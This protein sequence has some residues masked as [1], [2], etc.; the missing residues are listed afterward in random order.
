MRVLIITNYPFPYGMAQTNRLISISKG[1]QY[2][3]VSVKVIISKSTE[4]EKIR[5]KD[6]TGNYEGVDFQYAPKSTKRSKN[7]FKRL[8]SFL[9]GVYRTSRI[10]KKE[11]KLKKVDALFLG[12]HSN[13]IMLFLLFQAKRLGIKTVH[14]RSEYPFLSYKENFL[15]HLKLKTYLKVICSIFD[16]FIVISSALK[17]Y[18]SPY[19]GKNV[20]NF[21]LPILVETERFENRDIKSKNQIA[22][23]G[24]MQ[25]E[26]D[27][28]PILIE[29]FKKVSD[30]YPETT[31]KLIGSTDFEG[32]TKLKE[33]V[34]NLGLEN[35]IIFT[36][37]VERKFLPS[38]LLE[39][40]ILALARPA[41]KQAEGG[42]PTKLGEYL[43]TGRLTIVTK[44]GDIPEYLTHKQDALLANPGDI[45]SFANL[46][47]LGLGDNILSKKIGMTGQVRAKSVFNYKYQGAKLADWLKTLTIS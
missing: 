4:A 1:L 43:A 47:D 26:K 30:K 21:K 11:H 16:G 23:C 31:L 17:T 13:L 18:F 28:V 41:N 42:F 24:S 33:K 3:E 39:S 22:Y 19:L 46:L 8:L 32:F 35:R 10:I 12:V 14:E 6:I 44:V 34:R 38:L 37:R 45:D 36:G 5:N 9:M 20:K 29:A 2:N 25:G 7:Y 40:R 15:S 27:G